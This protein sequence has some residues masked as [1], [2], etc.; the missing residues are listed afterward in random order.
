MGKYLFCFFPCFWGFPASSPFPWLVEVNFQFLPPFSHLI[1][2]SVCLSLCPNFFLWRHQS[3]RVH[4]NQY[5]LILMWWHLQI[6]LFPNRVTLR[7]WVALNC[8]EALFNL[9]QGLNVPFRIWGFKLLVHVSLLW[10]FH[11]R[12]IVPFQEMSTWMDI[13]LTNLK[14]RNKHVDI[15]LPTINHLSIGGN[16]AE[17][18]LL[19]WNVSGWQRRKRYGQCRV[20]AGG[21][22]MRNL[23][24]S[25]ICLWHLHTNAPCVSLQ[26]WWDAPHLSWLLFS[27]CL[28]FSLS[29]LIAAFM[30][31]NSL[32]Y[33]P[34]W[35]LCVLRRDT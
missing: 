5:E 32:R 26:F 15:Y 18:K 14:P 19:V 29:L 34:P 16:D 8:V 24:S 25:H 10:I 30:T 11:L 9:T 12:S 23:D 21:V 20:G 33:L 17:Y 22:L 31:N 13:M 2:P 27:Q 35:C 28:D 7:L 6:Y 4:P 3:Y 1:L